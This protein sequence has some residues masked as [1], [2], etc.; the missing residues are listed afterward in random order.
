MEIVYT[1]KAYLGF[2]SPSLRQEIQ[3]RRFTG[4]FFCLGHS[5][6]SG[7][8]VVTRVGP[9]ASVS[10]AH[11]FGGLKIGGMESPWACMQGARLLRVLIPFAGEMRPLL[12]QKMIRKSQK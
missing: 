2:E 6:G 3:K 10:L 5:S 7:S 4:A 1:P 9:P 8:P 11:P 12:F